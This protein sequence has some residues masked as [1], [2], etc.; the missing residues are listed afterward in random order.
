MSEVLDLGAQSIEA[1]P[2]DAEA[3]QA[4]KDVRA[5]IADAYRDAFLEMV[6]TQRKMAS[7]LERIQNTLSLL[8]NHFELELGGKA[9]AAIR[10]AEP[11]TEPDL[12]SALLV[13]DPIAAGYT[14]NQ[15]DIARALG[16]SQPDVSTLVRAFRLPEDGACAVIVRKGKK[17]LSN[18]HPRAV[19]R[20]RHLIA[21]PPK[22]LNE[23][24]A[25][26]VERARRRLIEPA[27]ARPGS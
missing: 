22:G 18:Y 5:E 14:L 6:A 8:V 4:L 25:K 12:A 1:L 23:A 20:L 2:L 9:P 19:E 17:D 15:V 27:G 10:V 3:K 11:G 16:L 7:A 13:A 24:A 26:A 21:N